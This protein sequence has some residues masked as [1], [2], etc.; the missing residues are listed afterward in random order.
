MSHMDRDVLLKKV[1]ALEA[2]RDE[3][4]TQA[5]DR[6][7]CVTRLTGE[8]DAAIADNAVLLAFVKDQASVAC[9]ETT[10]TSLECGDCATCGARQL[11]RQPH[12]GAALLEKHAKALASERGARLAAERALAEERARTA[13]WVSN[14]R[15]VEIALG[16]DTSS[17]MTISDAHRVLVRARNDGVER[18]AVKY[19]TDAQAAR[20][21]ATRYAG[22]PIAREWAMVAERCEADAEAIRALNEPDHG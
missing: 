2:E 20:E 21:K 3:W 8:R 5:L 10:I 6:D 14:V 1:A 11:R 13:A 7:L 4:R 15:E 9:E 16:M 19:L 17:G 22:Q 12:P 18:V